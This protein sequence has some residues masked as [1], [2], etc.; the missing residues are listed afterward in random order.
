MLR[1]YFK[2]AWRNLI[3]NKVYSTI[4]I[5]GLAIGMAVA[6]LITLWIWDETSFNNYHANHK[7]LA[8]VMTTFFN[9]KNEQNT[10]PPVAMPIGN[11]LRTKYA[12]DFKN[13]SM[14]S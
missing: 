4:N 8:Q 7:Q 13:V 10:A 9:D 11:E 6:L 2:I 12:G 1:N 3:K 5:L 14:A